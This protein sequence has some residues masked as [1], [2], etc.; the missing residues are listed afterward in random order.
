MPI[1]LTVQQ[2]GKLLKV[3]YEGFEIE[4]LQKANFPDYNKKTLYYSL[5]RFSEEELTKEIKLYAR[6]NVK[7]YWVVGNLFIDERMLHY[8]LAYVLVP[9]SGN[10]AQITDVEVQLLYATLNKIQVNWVYVIMHHMSHHNENNASL[11]YDDMLIFCVE[12]QR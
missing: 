4:A 6:A 5:S 11:P 1:S 9:K 7:H 2:L 10:Y 8:F 3:P 12:V